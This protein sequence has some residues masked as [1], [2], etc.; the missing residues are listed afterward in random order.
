M[1][2]LKRINPLFE[3]A[4]RGRKIGSGFTLE[5]KIGY[6]L[7]EL[8][9]GEA[10]S[11]TFCHEDGSVVSRSKLLNRLKRLSPKKKYSTTIINN[12]IKILRTL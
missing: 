6:E 9:I 8:N 3:S 10:A 1:T 12:E 7:N 2:E 11:I 4:K 5:Y